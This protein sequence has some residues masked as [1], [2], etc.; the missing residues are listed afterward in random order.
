MSDSRPSTA[1]EKTTVVDHQLSTKRPGFFS[2]KKSTKALPPSEKHD[3]KGIEKSEEQ[4]ADEKADEK[5]EE[6]APVGFF[7]MFRYVQSLS[8]QPS[9]KPF[10]PDSRPSLRSL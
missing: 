3:E 9:S 8:V 7:E 10:N 4:L 2:R 6:I 1:D 5:K